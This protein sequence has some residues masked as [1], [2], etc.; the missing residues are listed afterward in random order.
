M[1]IAGAAESTIPTL[2]L[3]MIPFLRAIV[4]KLPCFPNKDGKI[5]LCFNLSQEVGMGKVSFY[6]S[7]LIPWNLLFLSLVDRQERQ[8]KP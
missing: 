3:E 8:V 6:F 4:S 5:C 7:P 2:I 1:K